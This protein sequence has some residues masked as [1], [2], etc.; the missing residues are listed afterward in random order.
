[1]GMRRFT[2]GLGAATCPGE[3]LTKS[4]ACQSE[5]WSFSGPVECLPNEMR[6]LF[7]RGCLAPHQ[8][9]DSTGELARVFSKAEKLKNIPSLPHRYFFKPSEMLKF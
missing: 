5:D 9:W 7:H 8:R 2:G 6:S 4:E 1:M 3:V